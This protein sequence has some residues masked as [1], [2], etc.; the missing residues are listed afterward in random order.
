MKP[1]HSRR[2]SR[3]NIINTRETAIWRLRHRVIM[4]PT[5]VNGND[6][7]RQVHKRFGQRQAS[8][9][10]VALQYHVVQQDVKDER[11]AKAVP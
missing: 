3:E 10:E 4:T 6:G 5:V 7:T 9:R 8:R 2:I 11:N 1:P